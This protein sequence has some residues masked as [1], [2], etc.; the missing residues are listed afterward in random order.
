MQLDL[1]PLARAIAQLETA[2]GYYN[3]P[4]AKED[5]KLLE[6]FRSAAIQA[7]EFT[8]DISHKMLKRYLEETEASREAIDH[9]KAA[10]LV[11]LGNERGLLLNDWSVWD[12]YRIARNDTSHAYDEK[13][14]EEVFAIIPNF[15]SEARYLLEKLEAGN[16]DL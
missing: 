6:V 14:A 13:K 11:R 3:S 16:A 7:F 5:P 2:L 15:L 1:S 8:H 10:N 9:A 12:T 4:L